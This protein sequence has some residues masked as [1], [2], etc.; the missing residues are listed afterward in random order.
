MRGHVWYDWG[1]RLLQ[2]VAISAGALGVWQF[3]ARI[4]ARYWTDLMVITVAGPCRDAGWPGEDRCAAS[5]A[6]AD[7]GTRWEGWVMGTDASDVGRPVSA[8]LLG[9]NAY[10]VNLGR[11]ALGILAFLVLALGVIPVVKPYVDRWYLPDAPIT[12]WGTTRWYR[13]PSKGR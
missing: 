8:W 3:G 4:F 10:P 11:E 12:P 5:W 1:A 13:Y 9:G 6:S 2:T 7:G